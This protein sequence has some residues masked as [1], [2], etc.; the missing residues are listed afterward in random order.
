MAHSAKTFYSFTPPQHIHTLVRRPFPSPSPLQSSLLPFDA[1]PLLLAHTNQSE[2][3]T[4]R[5]PIESTG[6]ARPG[7]DRVPLPESGGVRPPALLPPALPPA[8]WRWQ[9]EEDE[10]PAAGIRAEPMKA[11]A[12][13]AKRRRGP[14]LAV[15]ALVFC[16]LLVPIAFLFNR[17]PAGESSA[18]PSR[19][20]RRHRIRGMRAAARIGS[21]P[22]VPSVVV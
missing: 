14:R 22:A 9:G 12:P 18:C 2:H 13:P 15:L 16:S 7:P 1:L 21:A 8:P 11:T 6:A 20:P 3:P 5:S 17:F 19:D 4:P 10:A